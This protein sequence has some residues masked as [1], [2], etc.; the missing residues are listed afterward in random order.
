MKNLL[1]IG[2]AATAMLAGCSNDETVEMA[3][4]AAISFSN[5]FVNNGTRSIVDPSFT[6]ETLGS[7]AVY[8]FTQNGQIFDGTTVSSADQG[9][10]WTYSPPQYWVA[11]N[12]YTFGAIAPASTTVTGE[13]VVDGKVAMTVSFTN[14]GKVD[15]LHAAPL[16]ITADANFAANPTAVGM[17]FNHQLAK[18][19]FSFANE[20][21]EGYNVK[22]TN[23]NITN[24]KESGTLTIGADNVWSAQAGT[25][26]LDFGD[27]TA[28]DA[29]TDE[30]V[31]IANAGEAESYNEQ[32]M[33]PTGS[34]VTYTVTFTAELLQGDVP[35]GSFYHTVTIKNVELKLGY[36]Y[37]F[38]ATLTH[39]NIVDPENPLKPIEF[40]V[41]EIEDWIETDKD[42]TLEVP[43]P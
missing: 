40:T 39:E 32:L 30:A 25:L 33:I 4:P 2:L 3:Q 17:T 23:V 8:G 43:A 24:A 36:C 14:D 41:N 20:V 42:Q 35:V 15:L 16:A 6:K 37:D 7:F 27:A 18:V 31:A 9:A 11:G 34:D 21:G 13:A 28:A 22:V 1:F 5:A 10:T 26:I 12:T 19:K 29:T 38:K